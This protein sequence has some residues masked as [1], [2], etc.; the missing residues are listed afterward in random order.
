MSDN[1]RDTRHHIPGHLEDQ[2]TDKA[3]TSTSQRS[4]KRD[5]RHLVK[6][7]KM[8]LVL[9]IGDLHIP[10]RTHD[11]PAKF[12]KLLVSRSDL[13]S[14]ALG[15][16]RLIFVG[17]IPQVPGKIGQIL[18]TGN[19][20][21]KETYDYLRTVAPD[22]LSVRGDFDSVSFLY[23]Q[24]GRSSA[25]IASVESIIEPATPTICSD[26]SRSSQI[27]S[28]FG[29]TMYTCRRRGYSGSDIKTDGC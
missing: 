6:A 7:A 12:K 11:L 5:L 28:H 16:K 9:I 25:L 15:S 3:G 21:D 14:S 8:V 27:W 26:Q 20:C 24:G 19:I 2:T 1:V 13:T 29:H 17:S 4:I 23:Q 10:I 22:V 18:C